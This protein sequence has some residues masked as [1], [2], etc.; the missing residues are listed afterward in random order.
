MASETAIVG[1]AIAALLLAVAPAGAQEPGS[2]T[3]DAIDWRSVAIGDIEAA[4]TTFKSEHPG[5]HDPANPAFREQL[6]Q[7]R[8]NGLDFANRITKPE[9]YP[10]ALSAFSAA[11]RDG[12]AL[13]YP[14]P[15]YHEVLV[16]QVRWPGF[17]ANWRGTGMLVTRALPEHQSLVGAKIIGC[18]SQPIRALIER[19]VFSLNYRPEE[20]GQWWS[21]AHNLFI[22]SRFDGLDL[23]GATLPSK[24]DF[25][26]V[27]GEPKTHTLNWS[28]VPAN[29]LS[30]NWFYK[31]WTG[32][33]SYIGLTEPRPGLFVIGLPD[34]Q[35]SSEG[36]A[37]YEKLFADLARRHN[38]LA[39][40]R[41]I[42]IDMRSN[43]GGSSA[44]PKRVAQL[45]WGREF[46]DSTMDR[47][48]SNTSVWWRN[49]SSVKKS[50]QLYSGFEQLPDELKQGLG[51]LYDK[52]QR[53]DMQEVPLVEEPKRVQEVTPQPAS[54]LI[55]NI[56]IYVASDGGCA[57]SCNDGLDIFT[58]FP[59]TKLIG[60]PSSADSTYLEVREELTPS[61]FARMILP[62]KVYVGRPVRPGP[63]DTY[64]SDIPVTSAD[65]S[66]ERFLDLIEQDLAGEAS[67]G[68]LSLH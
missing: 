32:E 59:G 22:D 68:P 60:A 51:V 38:E 67:D 45:L 17:V 21:R 47:Y 34:F 50:V 64:P 46:I 6:E 63:A 27:N 31:S 57:S 54:P 39:H 4:Y 35:P 12:H 61:G 65:W 18:D 44:W 30:E 8:E 42:M 41:A 36:E 24:C 53:S 52:M 29:V 43:N 48:Y 56:R 66:T 1:A 25:V 33:N 49:T 26:Y 40:A 16:D 13:L 55:P 14:S 58:R 19:N 3:P 23:L 37:A 7:A 20:P 5:Y 15:A 62:M 9:H 11:L 2:A 28:A 10:I